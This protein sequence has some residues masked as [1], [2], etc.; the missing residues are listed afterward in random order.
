MIAVDF[1]ILTKWMNCKTLKQLLDNKRLSVSVN[2]ILS[3][4]F[5]HSALEKTLLFC[6]TL[7][8]I[9]SLIYSF[10]HSQL[11]GLWYMDVFLLVCLVGC[12]SLC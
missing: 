1:G 4:T 7:F 10:I 11:V 12:G 6:C 3:T 5:G 9:H 8:F 2:P